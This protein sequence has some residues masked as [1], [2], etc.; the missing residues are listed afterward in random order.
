VNDPAERSSTLRAECRPTPSPQREQVIGGLNAEAWGCQVSPTTAQSTDEP[1][2]CVPKEG[3]AG[4]IQARNHDLDSAGTFTVNRLVAEASVDDYDALLLPGATVNPDKLRIDDAA[5]SFVRDFVGSGKPVAVICRGPWTL[6]E[7]GVA[8]GRT[9]TSYPIVRTDQ[10]N[11]G[12]TVVDEEV[13]ILQGATRNVGSLQAI[14]QRAAIEQAGRTRP[15][16]GDRAVRMHFICLPRT[17][18]TL[19]PRA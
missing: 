11:A 12:A 8:E 1:A 5:V 16:R 2:D 9:V 13:V 10:R 15:P 14:A 7:A 17:I 4:E 18:R 6:V 3:E 19:L